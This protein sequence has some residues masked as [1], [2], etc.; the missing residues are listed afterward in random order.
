MYHCSLY[1]T[2]ETDGKGS[3]TP[4]YEIT[5]ILQMMLMSVL[6]VIMADHWVSYRCKGKG[7]LAF[8]WCFSANYMA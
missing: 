1:K 3:V 8:N 7:G 4:A 2:G 5:H 6:M